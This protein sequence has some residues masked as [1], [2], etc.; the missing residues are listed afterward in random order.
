VFSRSALART[1]F[2]YDETYVSDKHKSSEYCS[3]FSGKLPRAAGGTKPTTVTRTAAP[4]RRTSACT[5]DSPLE[6]AAAAA[7]TVCQRD[8]S[9][10]GVTF[11]GL[12]GLPM[13][14]LLPSL[15]HI[16]GHSGH[17][18]LP[19]EVIG[20]PVKETSSIQM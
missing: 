7:V 18:D 10:T 3:A 17:A 12:P 13:L 9:E 8:F 19:L 1:I 2:R 20:A 14:P 15:S 4:I 6:V 11:E 5:V 16:Q